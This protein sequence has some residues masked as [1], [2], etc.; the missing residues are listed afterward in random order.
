MSDETLLTMDERQAR[1]GALRE[2]VRRNPYTRVLMRGAHD[3]WS[4]VSNPEYRHEESEL[5]R[6]RAMPPHVPT[7]T[8][9]PGFPVELVDAPSFLAMYLDIFR[10]ERYRFKSQSTR[11]FI[12]DGGANIGLI[13]LYFKKLYPE[14]RIIAFEPDPKIFGVLERNVHG[15]GFRDVDLVPRALWI[16]RQKMRFT[17]EGSWWGRMS[18]S[19]DAANEQV[20]TVRLRDYLDRPVDLL[21]LDIEGAETEVLNDCAGALGMVR[22]LFVEYHSFAGEP[23]KVGGL[24]QLLSGAGFRLYFAAPDPSRQ[25]LIQRNVECNLDGA[26]NIFGVREP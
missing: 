21:K 13:T 9:L 18:R 15:N 25:P 20:E 19:G 10:L 22:N 5:A 17:S 23:Q 26:L 1:R 4:R 6:L 11:P 14:A 7:V 8:D 2:S 24:L 16:S 3:L 12:L